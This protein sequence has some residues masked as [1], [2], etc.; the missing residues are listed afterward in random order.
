MA[1]TTSRLTKNILTFTP[2]WWLVDATGVPA[3]RLAVKL[4][5]VLQG[6]NK[7]IYHPSVDVGDYV[8]VINAAKIALSGKKWDKKLYRHHTGFPG[9][10]KETPAKMLLE[11]K[12]TEIIRKATYGMLPKND[13]RLQRIRKLYVFPTDEHPYAQNVGDNIIQPPKIGGK[14]YGQ[15][16]D[17]P[18][19]V[20]IL[21]V[22]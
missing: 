1:S 15:S 9:G 4:S 17:L 7:P 20:E 14:I 3:G 21:D 22:K 13:L 10:L 6:K 18:L 5:E 16:Q 19:V 12:P 8:V 2:K 11:K